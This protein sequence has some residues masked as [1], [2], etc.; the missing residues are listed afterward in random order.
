MIYKNNQFFSQV[1]TDPKKRQDYSPLI[2]DIYSQTKIKDGTQQDTQGKLVYLINYYKSYN[3]RYTAWI[4][5]YG[6]SCGKTPFFPRFIIKSFLSN[7][8][9]A[10]TCSKLTTEPLEQGVKCSKLTIKTPERSHWRRSGVFI[11]NFE[12]ILHFVLVFLLLTLSS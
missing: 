4:E 12:H 2:C 10:I 8:Q 6:L 7:P 5:H 11:V 3:T 9:P 1:F